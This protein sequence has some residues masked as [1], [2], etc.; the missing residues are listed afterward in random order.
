MD[1]IQGSSVLCL[2]RLEAG[3]VAQTKILSVLGLKEQAHQPVRFHS[4]A[5][6]KNSDWKRSGRKGF[7]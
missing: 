4:V 5:M 3:S 2:L 7:I 1:W 6:I